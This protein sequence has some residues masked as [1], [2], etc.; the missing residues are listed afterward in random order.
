MPGQ[1]GSITV[2]PYERLVGEW[3]TR[4]HLRIDP[5]GGGLLLAN[6]SEAAYL[7]P[8]G[9]MMAQ[10]V[11]EER[12]DEE[13]VAEVAA[14]FRDAPPSQIEADLATVRQLIAD[15]SEPGD[16]YP[17]TNLADPARSEW[18]RELAAPLRADVDQCDL[19]RFRTVIGKLWAGGVPH[20]AIQADPA[21]D[22][23][24]LPPLVEAAGDIGMICGLRAVTSWLPADVIVECAN[25]GL[26]HLDL[27]YVSCDAAK[28]DQ[29]A[30]PGDHA[31]FAAA[32]Q[33]CRDLELALVAQVPLLDDN[34]MELDQI[35][36]A[37]QELGVTNVVGFAIA[38]PDGD[39]AADAAGALPARAVPQV[40]T[41]FFE[42]AEQTRG[43]YLWAPPVR[44][45][46]ARGLAAQILAGPRTSADVTV[47]VRADG[48]V[49]PPRGA[50]SCGDLLAQEWSAIWQHE[51]F[52]RYRQ[53]L[54]QPTRCPDCPDLP[55]CA[56]D[57]PKD[58]AGWSDDRE[59]GDDR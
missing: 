54:A 23:G 34:L 16:D 6:A 26:D 30:G 46:P 2:K 58:P 10:G 41:T 5:D 50:G 17:V 29:V 13:I 31:A 24:A 25:V 42:L 52:R 36:V 22:P 32:V 7:S 11:L 59:G 28:H 1:P 38:C 9:V 12:G 18:E 57:C 39:E 44:Y 49:Q 21:A 47:R 53:R 3:P 4:F 48:R 35:S 15:L 45:D 51:C 8:V 43:R 55:I 56:A 20:V 37:L 19:E 40:A 27:L 14:A 33:I